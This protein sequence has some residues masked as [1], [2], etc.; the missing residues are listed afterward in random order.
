M[1]KNTRIVPYLTVT[2]SLVTHSWQKSH[3]STA[4]ACPKNVGWNRLWP[5]VKNLAVGAKIGKQNLVPP[6]FQFKW[7]DLK[8]NMLLN[9]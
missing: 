8:L 1:I 2:L 7:V 3:F 6:V 5:S 9:N 4:K